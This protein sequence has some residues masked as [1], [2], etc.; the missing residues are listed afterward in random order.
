MRRFRSFVFG[1]VRIGASFTQEFWR[2]AELGKTLARFN[3]GT[4]GRTKYVD[5]GVFLS[6]VEK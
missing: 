5:L 4:G 6:I 3:P 1:L 2:I